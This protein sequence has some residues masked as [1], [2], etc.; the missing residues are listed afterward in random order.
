MKKIVLSILALALVSATWAQTLDRSIKPKPGPA[1]VISL[2]KTESFTLP[3]GMKVFVVENHKLPTIEC[4]IEFDIKPALEGEMAGY[5]DLMSELLLSGTTTRE[6]DQLNAEIDQMGASIN[7]SDKEIS[8]G[9]LKKY[10]EKIFDLMADIAMNTLMKHDDLELARKKMLSGLETQKNDPDAM[11]K[12]VSAV[13]N[14]GSNHP[15]GEVP[16][17]ESVNRISLGKCYDYYHTYFRP[18]VAYMAIVGDVTVAEVKPLV[19]K[20]FSKWQQADV[21]VTAYT[22]PTTSAT[23]LTKVSFA[24]RVGAVQSVTSVTYPVDLKPGTPD[25]I[26]AKVAN[27]ILGGGSAGRLFTGIREKHGWGYGAYSSLHEDELGGTFN[28]SGKF[29]NIVSDSALTAILD[30]MRLMQTEKVSDTTLQNTITYISGNFAIGLEDPRRVAQYAINIERYHI[31]KDYYQNYLKTLSAVTSADVMEMSKKYIRPENANIVVAGSQDDVAPKL[32]KFSADGKLDYYDY[33]GKPIKPAATFAAPAGMTADI[34]FKKY[35]AAIGGENAINAIKDIKIIGYATFQNIPII[36]T[37]VKK[38]P[39]K[40]WQGIDASMNGQTMTM[41]KEVFD[42]TKAYLSS[43]GQKI[44]I[45]GDTLADLAE[46]ADIA[47]DL[48]SEKY[49]IVRTL[50]GM[51]M[52][53]DTKC[54]VIEAVNK[55][56]KKST[57]YYDA[58]SGLLLKVVNSGGKVVEYSDYKEV[59]GA[60]GFKIPY[61]VADSEDGTTETVDKVQIN[62]G[63]DDDL[64]N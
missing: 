53:K 29:R 36:I 59:P 23:K 16:T 8:G 5:G 12:N 7:V 34:V 46:D 1:P 32:E 52:L 10:E 61:K 14:F 49:G 9:G 56:G 17:D 25:V 51:E 40:Y 45:V 24:P 30:E 38:A 44:N 47:K 20:Y 2:G 54:Y 41:Q 37:E 43:Q 11:V 39:N 21:P 6:K 60:N 35:I 13:V 58:T 33:S 15:Y 63:I 57:E 50:K 64:F 42:G 26:K 3:N 19:E 28:A 27:T 62:K 55:R 22:I 4:N 48:H 31:P 18:N